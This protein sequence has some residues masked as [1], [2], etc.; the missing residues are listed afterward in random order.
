MT[1]E[2]TS[3]KSPS[4]A[5]DVKVFQIQKRGTHIIE[6]LKANPQF[7]LKTDMAEECKLSMI[8]ASINAP[9]ILIFNKFNF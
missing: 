2:V 7:L 8:A 3:N 6:Y 4:L 9:S 5:N 1:T